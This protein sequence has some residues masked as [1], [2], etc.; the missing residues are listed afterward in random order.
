VARHLLESGDLV[1]LPLEERGYVGA[2]RIQILA[3]GANCHRAQVGAF[4]IE[5]L[6][7]VPTSVF[8]AREMR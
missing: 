3:C 4:L 7:G 1:A 5:Q 2:E 6:A 8:Y